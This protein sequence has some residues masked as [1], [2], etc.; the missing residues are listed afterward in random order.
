LA[1]ALAEIARDTLRNNF[2][3]INPADARI[4]LLEGADRVL[5][6]FPPDLS[7]KAGRR[8][9]HLGVTVRT[10]AKVTDIRLG[11]GMLLHGGQK[12]TIATRT[13]LWAAGVEA[14]PLARKIA[15]ATG[16]KLDRAGRVLVQPDLT[17]PGHP[18]VFVIGDMA[19]FSHQ[20]GK[21]LPGVAQV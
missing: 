2:R 10:D 21:P 4:F 18:E 12:E 7:M 16:A 5:P 8:L 3:D 14:S 19:S 20:D 1:G 11:G 9:A 17:V 15:H 13:A 6:P